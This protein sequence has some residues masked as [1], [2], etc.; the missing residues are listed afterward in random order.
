MYPL[1]TKLWT[2]RRLS[3]ASVTV[4]SI[5]LLLQTRY[6]LFHGHFASR[7]G[8][9]FHR[10]TTLRSVAKRQVSD[11]YPTPP[12][13]SLPAPRGF[14]VPVPT[15]VLGLR[16]GTA[17]P[18]GGRVRLSRLGVVDSGGHVGLAVLGLAAA[19]GSCGARTSWLCPGVEAGYL[20]CLV[21]PTQ[22]SLSPLCSRTTVP[23]LVP[24]FWQP[25]PAP[26]SGGLAFLYETPQQKESRR[27]L[28]TR[29]PPG[30]PPSSGGVHLEVPGTRRR[31]AAQKI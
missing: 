8:N 16:L 2:L 28:R 29:R 4:T 12:G 24:P 18:S 20:C 27:T 5:S 23:T 22:A 26:N 21:L 7:V 11:G 17:V 25:R 3:L 6:C 30:S 14:S 19:L 10:P 15:L 1:S 13:F 31:T 9:S